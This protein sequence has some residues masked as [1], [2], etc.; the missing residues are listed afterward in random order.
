MTA[1]L[2]DLPVLSTWMDPLRASLQRAVVSSGC[3]PERSK[4]DVPVVT[5]IN[6]CV[7]RS[8]VRRGL[9]YE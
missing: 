6:R 8:I 7:S 3:T 9:A 2:P 1:E 5:Y 4:P